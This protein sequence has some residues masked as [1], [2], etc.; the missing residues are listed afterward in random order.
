MPNAN[1]DM[2][3]PLPGIQPAPRDPAQ[4]TPLRLYDRGE[5]RVSRQAHIR[6]AEAG[7]L[8]DD[9]PRDQANWGACAGPLEITGQAGVRTAI[10]VPRPTATCWAEARP[11]VQDGTFFEAAVRVPPFSTTPAG[12]PG[13]R[14]RGPSRW[15]MV[16]ADAARSRR[17]ARGAGRSLPGTHQ[18][19]CR[20]ARADRPSP[21]AVYGGIHGR[22]TRN[23][24][25]HDSGV[26][27]WSTGPVRRTINALT[28]PRHRIAG[29]TAK[30]GRHERC[31]RRPRRHLRRRKP[32]RRMGRHPSLRQGRPRNVSATAGRCMGSALIGAAPDPSRD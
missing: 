31:G 6:A 19:A 7:L 12:S 25:V 32:D 26:G 14:R 16:L 27:R 3:G 1:L 21:G 23:S 2:H 30:S 13:A 17:R 10:M 15:S 9:R 20:A 22:G 29:R 28:E 11:L 24:D 18:L 4:P 8:C 5:H